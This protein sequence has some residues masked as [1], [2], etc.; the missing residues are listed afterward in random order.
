W[1]AIGARTTESQTHREMASGLSS[2]VGFKNGTDGNLE[3]AV[4]AL[5]A[6]ARPHSLLGITQDGRSAVFHTRGNK[7]GHVVLRGEPKPNYDAENVR[8]CEELLEKNGLARNIMVDC[9]HANS[10]KDPERQPIVF[11]DC[12]SQIEAGNESIIGFMI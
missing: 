7:Y 3:V 6:A 12:M 4:N 5:Q 2:P 8:R 10:L 11:D 9:S 1:T